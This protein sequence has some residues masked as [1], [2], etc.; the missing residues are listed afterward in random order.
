MAM[1]SSTHQMPK[2]PSVRSFST[3]SAG[4]T[5]AYESGYDVG[6]GI[7]WYFGGGARSHAINGRC[8]DPYMPVANNS[9]FLVDQQVT[10]RY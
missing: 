9:S 8:A 3:P 6:M 1:K 10:A 5:A 2:R 7:A 4:P